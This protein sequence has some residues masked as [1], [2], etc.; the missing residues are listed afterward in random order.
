MT[1]HPFPIAKIGEAGMIR[2]MEAFTF[3][4]ELYLNMG[5]YHMKLDTDAQYLCTIVTPWQMA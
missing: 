5:Y 4:S 2:S 3:A 1:F